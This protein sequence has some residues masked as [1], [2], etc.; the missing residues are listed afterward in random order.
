[1]VLSFFLQRQIDKAGDLLESSNHCQGPKAKKF[2]DT[3]QTLK[4]EI[5]VFA[6]RLEDIRLR[7]EDTSRCFDLLARCQSAPEEPHGEILVKLRKAAA[8]SGNQKLIE[9]CQVINQFYFTLNKVLKFFIC[10]RSLTMSTT[11]YPAMNQLARK[12]LEF[13]K[14]QKE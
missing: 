2:K 5:S 6:D 7:L 13:L 1:M 12:R 11:T 8:K 10:F 14:Y 3:V 9:S 4:Q